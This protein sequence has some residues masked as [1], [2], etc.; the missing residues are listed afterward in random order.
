MASYPKHINHERSPMACPVELADVDL[1]EINEAFAA[2]P[3][4][5]M[6]ELGITPENVNVNGGDY[7]MRTAM[8]LAAGNG[9]YKVVEYLCQNGADVNVVD[10]WGG[11]PLDDAQ[12]DGHK[13]CVELLLKYGARY[14]KENASI[15]REALFDLFEQYAKTRDGKRSLDWEDVKALLHGIGHEPKDYY[16]RNL[17]KVV[18]EDDNGYIDKEGERKYVREC[19]S[20]FRAADLLWVV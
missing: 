10:R 18:D 11:R 13:D 14:G 7:D 5:A 17:F 19:L 1:F 12:F 20:T 6:R 4:K 9:H 3:L 8:H 2:I 16:V 15:E